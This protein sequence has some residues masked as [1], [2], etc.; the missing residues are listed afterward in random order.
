MIS[1]RLLL[2]AACRV[3]SVVDGSF[4]IVDPCGITEDLYLGHKSLE[5]S[6]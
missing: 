6:G 2:D 5:H 1:V 4:E 3:K